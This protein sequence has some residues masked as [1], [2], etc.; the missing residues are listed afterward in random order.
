MPI[1][2]LKPKPWPI[3][4]LA[5]LCTKQVVEKNCLKSPSFKYFDINQDFL[6]LIN[7]KSVTLTLYYTKKT[8]VAPYV[9][10]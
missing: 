2:H 4:L 10:T 5:K 1:F 9:H 6:R 3:S 7:S 8:A